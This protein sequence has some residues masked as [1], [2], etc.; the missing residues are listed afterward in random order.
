MC[1]IAGIIDLA[2]QRPV[3]ES[4]IQRMARALVHRGPNEEGFLVRPGLGLASRR[5]SIVGL[6]D[7]Q[8]PVS[9]ED[10]SVFVVF[11][12]ELFDYV[13]R[14]AD[15]KDRG[16]QLVTHCDTEIIPHMWE[17]HGDG[18]WER[19]RGQ[20]AI[21]LWDAR[22]RQLQLGRDRFG[23][24]P[25]FWTRQG[26]WLLFASEIKGLLA[27]GMV[28]AQ[29]DRRGID[30]V[31]TFSAVPGPRTCFEGVQL[32]P[33]GHFLNITPA[34]SNGAEA[35][36]EQ[37][38]FWEM[39]FPDQGAEERGENP[40][41]LVDDFEKVL[42]QAVEERLRADVPVGA[43][44]SGGVDSSMIVALACHLK[45]PAINTYTVRVHEPELDELDA[46]TLSARHIGAKPPIVQDFRDEDALATYPKLITAAET[47]VIDTAC[48]ALLQ[49]SGRVHSCGQKVVL[50]G[51]GADEWLVGYPWYKAAKLMGFLDL[52]PGVT[53]SNFARNAYLRINKVPHFQNAWR[54]EVE[55]S[56]GGPNAWIDAYGL[57]AISKLRFYSEP[58][59][60]MAAQTNPWTEL[61]FPLERARRWHP[62]HR[63]VWI[64][65]RVL[66]AGHLL[67]AKGDRVAMHNS[68]EVRYPFLDEDVFDFLAKLH[69][70][71]RLRGFRDKHLLRLLAERWVPKSVAR[72]HKVIF[73]APLDSFHMDPEPPFV[74]QLLSDES[75]RKTGYF[76]MIEVNRWRNDFR[77]MRA[78][79]LPRL[80]VEMGLMAVIATQLWHHLF[81]GDGLADLPEWSSIPTPAAAKAA[82]AA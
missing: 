10:R 68:V 36:V 18:M 11:N 19:L 4:N 81:I 67:Q 2:G 23:I 77:K 17:D 54:R 66:L 44:L 69:P 1:G 16:H 72:R 40:R 7:G 59:R 60:Q 27:S 41:R 61:S 31:F 73:R 32:L 28:P 22:K 3:F 35:V 82:V 56:V 78:G 25:L 45:G 75:L 5:L 34:S 79:S 29:P 71:W 57:L 49:L 24:A 55:N 76:D 65:A 50:T 39:D 20:F 37:R 42:L 26:D 51:E 74:A 12:G 47:P 53:L 58:M 30:H 64:A 48:A 9:N 6:A 38:A 52:M 13:E 8:Q 33:P 46:A 21:A 80:S 70:R 62:L 14:R 63:G 15:L 43:Y